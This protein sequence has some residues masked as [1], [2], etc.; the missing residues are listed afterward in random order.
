LQDK[1]NPLFVKN[2]KAYPENCGF[3]RLVGSQKDGSGIYFISFSC[4][5]KKTEGIW[6][7]KV[8]IPGAQSI[9]VLGANTESVEA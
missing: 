7:D 4:Y 6:L 8:I 9:L 5:R 2:I 3:L 1:S